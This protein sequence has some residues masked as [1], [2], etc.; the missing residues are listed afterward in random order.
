MTK[1]K[2]LVNQNYLV[3]TDTNL[4][5]NTYDGIYATDLL[6]QAIHAAKHKQALI[7]IIAN[8]NTVAVA[9]MMELSLIIISSH[10]EVSQKIIDKANEEHITIISTKL[11]THEVIIDMYQRGLI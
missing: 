9:M 11:H 6:S 7:T 5:E 3:L 1:I 8:L 4:L 2:D 10:K